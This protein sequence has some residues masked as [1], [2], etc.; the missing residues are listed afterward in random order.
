M[1]KEEQ[2]VVELG[3]LLEFNL[4]QNPCSAMRIVRDPNADQGH[5]E[6]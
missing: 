6:E 5:K 2:I 4:C 1:A 3:W